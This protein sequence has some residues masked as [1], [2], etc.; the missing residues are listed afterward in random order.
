VRDN[1]SARALAVVGA[2][3]AGAVTVLYWYVI[4]GQAD[5]DQRRPQLVAISLLIAVVLLLA[6]TVIRSHGMQLLLLSTASSTLVIWTVLG[7]LSIGVLLVPAVVASLVAASKTSELVRPGLA[8]L[9]AAAGAA[10]ALL[11]AFV[12]FGFS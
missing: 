4:S 11:L 9:V 8:W 5:Q 6:S 10:N 7:A 12:V 2:G 3:L 1:A